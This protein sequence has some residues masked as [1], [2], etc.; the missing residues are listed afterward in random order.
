MSSDTLRIYIPIE[1]ARMLPEAERRVRHE[2]C[3]ALQG[4]GIPAS[5]VETDAA[6]GGV[7]DQ[8]EEVLGGV[9]MTVRLPAATLTELVEVKI[10]EALMAAGFDPVIEPHE[11]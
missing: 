9:T 1:D 2:T 7:I 5:D 3:E 8:R 11:G 4:A 10:L 6:P